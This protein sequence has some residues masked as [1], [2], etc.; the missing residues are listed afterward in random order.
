MKSKI[1]TFALLVSSLI[2][3]GQVEKNSKDRSRFGVRGGVNYSNIIYGGDADFKPKVGF[4]I[5]GTYNV[6][7]SKKF[8]LPWELLYSKIGSTEGD[9]DFDISMININFMA[10]YYLNKNVYLEGGIP[11]SVFLSAKTFN[12]KTNKEYDFMEE[13]TAGLDVGLAVGVGYEFTNRMLVNVRYSY[14][15]LPVFIS[16]DNSSHLSNLSLNIG[17][18]F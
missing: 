17:Y 16:D 13:T 1:L 7:S 6:V 10:N 9:V 5:G 4:N 11:F 18:S 3:F 12:N 15:F 2:S 14:G 8:T